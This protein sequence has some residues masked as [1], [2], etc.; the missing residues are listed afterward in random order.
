MRY[1]AD[2][3]ALVRHFTKQG[4]LGQTA[5]KILD[6][7]D[8]NIHSV[9]ISA[10]TLM[11]IM[12]LSQAKRINLDLAKTVQLISQSSNYN[13]VAVD[14]HI[15]LASK[16]IDD[17]PELHDRVIVGTANYLNVPIITSDKVIMQSRHIQTVW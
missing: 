13:I 1:L 10:I 5:R 2:T 4:R 12:Y 14:E 15:I 17:V 7:T 8:Q 3:V 16:E 11:E 6:E 9:F